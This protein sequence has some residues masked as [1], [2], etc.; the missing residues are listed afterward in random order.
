MSFELKRKEKV[1]DGIRRVACEQVDKALAVLRGALRMV[2]SE[3]GG[4]SFDREN[5]T[6]EACELGKKLFAESDD[7]FI[8][9]IHGYWKAWR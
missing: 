2:K 3:L 8:D 9:R 7:E 6:F 5:R 4:K 1:S